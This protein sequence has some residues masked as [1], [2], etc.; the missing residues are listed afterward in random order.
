VAGYFYAHPDPAGLIY[1]FA[2]EVAPVV[3]RALVRRQV[4]QRGLE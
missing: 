2:D 4:R 1:W 3:R